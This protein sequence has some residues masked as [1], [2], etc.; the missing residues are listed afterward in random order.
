MM[1]YTTEVTV[2]IKINAN[3]QNDARIALQEMNYSF[4]FIGDRAEITNS[5]II[6]QVVKTKLTRVA[7]KIA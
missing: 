6:G 3:S 4:D 2:R 7:A 1:T 5:Q